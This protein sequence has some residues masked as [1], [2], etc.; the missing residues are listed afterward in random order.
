MS[1]K[2]RFWAVLLIALLVSGGCGE[3]GRQRPALP[4]PSAPA[5]SK[6]PAPVPEDETPVNG[7]AEEPAFAPVVRAACEGVG[8]V[9]AVS[10]GSRGA[11]ILLLEERHDSRAG[12][13][14]QA[15]VLV[16]LYEQCGLRDVAL[17]GYLE[18]D[19][20]VTTEWYERVARELDFAAKARVTTQLLE[21]G[22][23]SSAE[24]M[25]LLYPDIRLHRT[26]TESQYSVTM[27][28]ISG[29]APLVYLLRIAERS[30]KDEHL[31]TLTQLQQDIEDAE[32]DAQVEKQRELFDYLLGLDPWT[33]EKAE[34]LEQFV[35]RPTASA[36]SHLELIEEID[37]RAR[38]LSVHLEPEDK[39]A[40]AE[41]L[42]FLRGR[43]EA[44]QT[45]ARATGSV[46]DQQSLPMVA[47]T[48]GAGHTEAMVEML[49][50]DGRPFA[51]IRPKSFDDAAEEGGAIRP[52]G[53]Q[54]KYGLRSV[55]SQGV[56]E[57]LSDA[58]PPKAEKKP[59]P[60]IP[61]DWF[62]AHAELRVFT[63]RLVQRLVD[64][65]PAAYGGP[66]YGYREDELRTPRVYV[67][68][69]R[70]SIVPDYP[71][72]PQQ[73]VLFPVVFNPDD[74][75]RRQE[76]WFK[77]TRHSSMPLSDEERTDVEA[78]LRH[79]L[80]KVKSE[81]ETGAKLEDDKGRFPITLS[82]VAGVAGTKEAARNIV[83][84]R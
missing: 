31:P 36:Q 30:V 41:Y 48:M 44:N 82:S 19:P 60:V 46:A 55:Y 56:L 12:Q 76:L 75:Q 83:L 25:K 79:A 3:A 16:R 9:R 53:I 39:Q 59:K 18:G 14:E 63:E 34:Q 15:I 23:I 80:D 64:G 52:D 65:D 40:M 69:S 49:R 26:E 2:L 7:P 74:A 84:T 61:Y 8:E 47:L 42:G 35:D 11:P 72:S 17:E 62:K 33:R 73:T 70:I 57:R 32:G 5:Q 28:E 67:D 21:T 24:F 45:I 4:S 54:R 77:A 78:M 81:K 22:E 6:A 1:G 38:Q 43:G 37:R 71:G 68:P 29:A 58:F 13:I 27:E 10:G 20:E 50:D 66:P 51:V